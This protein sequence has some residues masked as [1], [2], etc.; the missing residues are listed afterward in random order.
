MINLKF[1]DKTIEVPTG[2]TCDKCKTYY[3]VEDSVEW[4]EKL[5]VMLQ[6]GWGCVYGD[7]T[8]VSFDICQHCFADVFG[9][10]A[11]YD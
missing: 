5:S 10:F 2:F 6:G 9:E 11:R 7:G 1:E 3:A 4:Q 8:N